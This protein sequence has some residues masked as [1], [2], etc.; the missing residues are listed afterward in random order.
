MEWLLWVLIVYYGI[1][2]AILPSEVNKPRRVT[3]G[4]AG[5]QA[6]IWLL[7]IIGLLVMV[8]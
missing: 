4:Q 7:I 2:L 8:L 3:P 1:N 5:F 6:L